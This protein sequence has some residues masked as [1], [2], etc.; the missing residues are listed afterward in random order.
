[1]VGDSE[2]F[3]PRYNLTAVQPVC[4][5]IT[6]HCLR[7]SPASLLLQG[8]R[9]AEPLQPGPESNP[10]CK[11]YCNCGACNILSSVIVHKPHHGLIRASTM[12]LHIRLAA[13]ASSKLCI[14]TKSSFTPERKPSA[15]TIPYH[16]RLSTQF[17]FLLSAT[18]TDN[19]QLAILSCSHSSL[20]THHP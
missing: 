1:M 18:D 16:R 19:S 15:T 10:E 9:S 20:N 14:I 4:S 13:G 2:S 8:S 17:H 12:A 11:L 6:T 7:T 5:K 3:L